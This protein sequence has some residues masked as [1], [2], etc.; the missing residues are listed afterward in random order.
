[1]GRD[2][3]NGMTT[4]HVAQ[5]AATTADAI[6]H[7]VDKASDGLA[8]ITHTLSSAAPQAWE[9]AVRGVYAKG[10]STLIVGGICFFLLTLSAIAFLFLVRAASKNGDESYIGP[11]IITGFVT[12]ILLL[13]TAFN[14]CDADAWARVVSPDGYLAQQILN[15]AIS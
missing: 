14:V 4:E 10:L 3:R 1:M 15:K 12:F 5:P 8:Q 9:M 2:G 6:N 13:A 7:L 11:C